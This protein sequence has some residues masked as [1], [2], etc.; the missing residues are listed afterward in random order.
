MLQ[1]LRSARTGNRT[2]GPGRARSG[3]REGRN[4]R[5]PRAAW[6]AVRLPLADAGPVIPGVP[7]IG[8]PRSRISLPVNA[9]RPVLW[10]RWGQPGTT[11]VAVDGTVDELGTTAQTPARGLICGNGVHPCGQKICRA[12]CVNGAA[13]PAARRARVASGRVS[14]AAGSVRAVSASPRVAPGSRRCAA[15]PAGPAGRR[16]GPPQPPPPAHRHRLPRAGPHRRARA[17]A[18][19]ADRGRL[20]R[21]R[22]RCAAASA[23]PPRAPSDAEL[24]ARAAALSARYLQGRAR[25]DLGALGRQPAPAL[26]LVH[27]AGRLDPVVRPAAGDAGRTS[28]TTCCCTSWRTCSCRA[29]ARRSTRC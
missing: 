24:S 15:R 29:T 12:R 1:A 21:P 3:P 8:Q 2:A 16:R 19:V 23:G 6:P 14:A 18:D 17:G 27:P 5:N 7:S 4:T 13:V 9:L 22:P 20:V 11:R 26:G 25:A 10:T 28:S